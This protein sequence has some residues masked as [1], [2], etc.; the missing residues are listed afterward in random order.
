MTDEQHNVLSVAVPMV[1]F[2]EQTDRTAFDMPFVGY[3][4]VLLVSSLLILNDIATVPNSSN[5]LGLTS[6]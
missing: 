3:K 4:L 2:I 6:A 1:S 5:S